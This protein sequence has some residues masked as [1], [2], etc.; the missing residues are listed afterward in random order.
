MRDNY[1]EQKKVTTRVPFLYLERY[2][3][4]LDDPAPE[5]AKKI[6][7]KIK[8]KTKL[9]DYPKRLKNSNRNVFSPNH[10]IKLIM[11]FQF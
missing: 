11:I 8:V 10:V 2:F 9:V 4:S 5:S 6:E 7:S 1:F 3:F